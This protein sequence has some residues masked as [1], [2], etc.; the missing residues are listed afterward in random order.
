MI[1]KKIVMVF[2][3][4]LLVVTL[5]IVC[6]I[7]VFIGVWIN[8]P[9][10]SSN[11][12]I[13][14]KESFAS[15][16][17]NLNKDAMPLID[18]ITVFKFKD[19]YVIDSRIKRCLFKMFTRLFSPLEITAL[20][21]PQSN[22]EDFDYTTIITSARL[23]RFI[24]IL[25]YFYAKTDDF[26]ESSTLGK[27]GNWH[28]ITI[29]DSSANIK[30]FAY[31][32]DTIV[33]SSNTNTMEKLLKH[34]KAQDVKIEQTANEK[35]LS[36][37]INDDKDILE[38]H[39]EK[40]KQEASYDLFPS[41]KN[42]NNIQIEL[43]QDAGGYCGIMNF[44]FDKDINFKKAEKDVGFLFQFIKRAMDANCYQFNSTREHSGNDIL[45]NFQLIKKDRRDD[46]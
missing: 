29:N 27:V 40:V 39:I 30:S 36:V 1:S 17:L 15:I 37:N 22:P 21:E 44:K 28:I 25:Y 41:I 23:K 8:L 19:E 14:S 20:I 43:E 2:I 38:Y 26:K 4:R 18:E 31:Y 46:L 11:L 10:D 33:I 35:L 45:V 13:Y 12:D 32:M 34:G 42:L 7:F 24:E 9:I 16:K 5:I 6:A 3:R